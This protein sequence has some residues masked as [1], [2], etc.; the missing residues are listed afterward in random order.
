MSIYAIIELI[1]KGFGLYEGFS[2]YLIGVEIARMNLKL[3]QLKSTLEK[4]HEVK[5]Q[6]D[7][8][9]TQ[10]SVDSNTL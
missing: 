2:K 7:I 3:E 1:L 9:R 4:I 5:S 8:L 6:A 10:S